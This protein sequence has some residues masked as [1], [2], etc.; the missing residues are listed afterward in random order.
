M[1][2]KVSVVIPVYNGSNYLKEAIE[3]ALDQ[4]YKHKEIIVVNDGS[5]DRGATE[6]IAKCFGKKIRYFKKK[7]GGSGSALNFG[8]KKMT[9][10]WF[11]WLSH[12]DLLP[13]NRLT[14]QICV[15]KKYPQA[16]FIYGQ[17]MNIDPSGKPHPKLTEIYDFIEDKKIP[18]IRQMLKNNVISCSTTLVHKDVFDKV[19]L[20]NEKN[21]NA[22]DYEMWMSIAPFYKMYRCPKLA[23]KRRVHAEMSTL[24]QKPIIKY[25]VKLAVTNT[26]NK[27]SI[28]QFFPDKLTAISSYQ[29]K[30]KCYMELG[31]L[32]FLRRKWFDVTMNL[33]QKAW[34][35]DNTNL[36][37][38]IRIWL[39]PWIFHSRKLIREKIRDRYWQFRHFLQI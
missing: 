1:N 22:L 19:G 18:L 7:N 33:Y 6:R 39:S 15:L 27:F 14:E 35:L 25:E 2:P 31:D 9:G 11:V 5:T 10:V 30:A 28:E 23:I 20:F 26:L 29:A 37:I 8:I 17:L 34:Q 13:K 24:T 36:S 38:M 32:L 16:K 3:S 4:T 21:K 12:D